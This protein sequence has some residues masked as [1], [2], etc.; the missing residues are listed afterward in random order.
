MCLEKALLLRPRIHAHCTFPSVF[1]S[2]YG[3]VGLVVKA[4]ASRTE[5]PWI[6]SRL[7]RDLSRSSHTSDLKIDTPVAILPDAWPHRVNAGTGWPGVGIPWLGEVKSLICNF[8]LSVAA[9]NI[10]WADPSLRYT[11]MLLGR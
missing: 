2:V 9:R 11:S 4:S 7:R 1:L 6:D 5:D 10:V 3:L 8:C